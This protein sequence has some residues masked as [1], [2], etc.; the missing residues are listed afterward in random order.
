[1]DA[2]DRFPTLLI[3]EDQSELRE[4]LAAMLS[5]Q[6]YRILG[7][8]ADGAEAVRLAEDSPPDVALLDYRMPE[9]DGLTAATQIRALS[10]NVQIVM[11]TAYDEP[12]LSRDAG[13]AGISAFLVKGCAPSEILQA[14]RQAWKSKQRLDSQPAM[15]IFPRAG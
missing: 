2:T 3:A 8:A 14:L 11:F 1:M 6:G 10:P 13:R 4:A 7:P 15:R 5:G 9:I 12:S